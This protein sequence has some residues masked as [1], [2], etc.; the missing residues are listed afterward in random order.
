M[1]KDLPNRLHLFLALKWVSPNFVVI[2]YLLFDV[3]Y[4]GNFQK[5]R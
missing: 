3:F 5:E 4:Y 2:L 1:G